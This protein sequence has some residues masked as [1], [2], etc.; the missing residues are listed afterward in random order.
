MAGVIA[1]VSC[2]TGLGPPVRWGGQY[3]SISSTYPSPAATVKHGVVFYAA[4]VKSN[5]YSLKAT[6]K[7]HVN[8]AT[9]L[10]PATPAMTR[11]SVHVIVNPTGVT[12][13]PPKT[14]SGGGFHWR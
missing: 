5:I 6:G 14:G 1:K 11:A 9:Q 2:M 8:K 3:G 7:T 13:P 10:S 12:P 4:K